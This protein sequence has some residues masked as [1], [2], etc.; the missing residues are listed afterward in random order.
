MLLPGRLQLKQS[1]SPFESQFY[2]DTPSLPGP[3]LL[4]TQGPCLMQCLSS[5]EKRTETSSVTH[6]PTVTSHLSYL[7][8]K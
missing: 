6:H 3:A 2:R 7:S 5:L 4:V 1:D 8:S